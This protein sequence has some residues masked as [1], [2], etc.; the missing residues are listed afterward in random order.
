MAA[1][2][3]TGTAVKAEVTELR[4][5]TGQESIFHAAIVIGAGAAGKMGGGASG[6]KRPNI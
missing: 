6:R 4:S 1:V 3:A 5:Q 2:A